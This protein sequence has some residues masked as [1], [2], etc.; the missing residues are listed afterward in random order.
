MRVYS[1]AVAIGSSNVASTWQPLP[2]AAAEISANKSKLLGLRDG[3]LVPYKESEPWRQCED[4]ILQLS[5]D[6]LRKVARLTHNRS[7][8]IIVI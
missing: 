3:A 1:I 4:S 2:F 8:I 6:F 7:H 5:I